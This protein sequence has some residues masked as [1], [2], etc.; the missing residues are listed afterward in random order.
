MRGN[1][2][3]RNEGKKTR[4][5]HENAK[6][7]QLLGAKAK[8]DKRTIQEMLKDYQEQGVFDDFVAKTMKKGGM[9]ALELLKLREKAEDKVDS[10]EHGELAPPREIRLVYDEVAIGSSSSVEG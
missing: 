5:T 2:N 3:I 8:R 6:E 4:I 1:P 9:L 7:M 10:R